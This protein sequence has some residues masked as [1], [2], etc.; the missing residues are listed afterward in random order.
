MRAVKAASQRVVSIESTDTIDKAIA[1]M[2]EHGI[3][4][5][6]VLSGT[7]LVG[8]LSDRD[9]LLS[10]GWRS[11]KERVKR[12]LVS[13]GVEVAGPQ[14]VREIMSSPVI[15]I[16]ADD[17][18]ADAARL[19]ISGQLHALPV[20]ARGRMLGI[21]T[22]TDLLRELG[23]MAH[24]N[25]EA[26]AFLAQGVA[27]LMRSA[28]ATVKPTDTIGDVLHIF[29]RLR[30]KHAPVLDE[31]RLIGMISDRDVRRAIGQACVEDQRAEESGEMYVGPQ[32]VREIMSPGA[33]TIPADANV[34]DALDAFLAHNI[35]ALPIIR[36]GMLC[37]IVTTTDLL[38]HGARLSCFA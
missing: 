36:E 27:E 13:E 20:V 6:P 14:R 26:E 7:D 19:M 34:R 25:A 22:D 4:H 5:L 30:T 24:S 31:G 28:V 17:T 12:S 15:T 37:G 35:H 1:L 29:T 33:V 8:I 10:V 16:T 2:E 3:H 11:A 9:L 23:E 21:V 38:R 32:R 18:E